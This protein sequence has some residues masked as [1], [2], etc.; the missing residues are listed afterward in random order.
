MLKASEIYLLNE[1]LDGKD[2]Y[3]LDKEAALRENLYSEVKALDSLKE[4]MILN[5]DNTINACSYQL[6]KGLE[7]FKMAKS[8]IW[9][10]DILLSKDDTDY[11]I[12][13]KKDTESNVFEL[14]KMA[15]F[16]LVLTILKEYEFLRGRDTI[17]DSSINNMEV[18]DFIENY[19][20][21]NDNQN[22]LILKKEENVRIPYVSLYITYIEV[23][24][25]TYKY[26]VL[27]KEL[28]E[29]SPKVV[30]LDISKL[31]G[32]EVK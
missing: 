24:G 9:V 30:R 12:F 29:V 8:Y 28:C 25:K 18:E 19:I 4:K 20:I 5:E 17:V 11:M 2:I 1:A 21:K 7:K 13:F 27:K 16:H 14:K 23:E 10:N 26:D 32:V 6:I 31:L 15:N 22:F 3:G